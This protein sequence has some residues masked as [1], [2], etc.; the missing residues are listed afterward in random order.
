[1][2]GLLHA[3]DRLRSLV[4]LELST[5]EEEMGLVAS[6]LAGC[7]LRSLS[8]TM[9]EGA[10]AEAFS[11]MCTL[12]QGSLTRLCRLTLDG[13]DKLV[14]YPDD[15]NIEREPEWLAPFIECIPWLQSL[16]W[17]CLKGM[18]VWSAQSIEHFSSLCVSSL[19][20]CSLLQLDG[21]IGDAG[22]VALA[23]ACRQGA[24]RELQTLCLFFPNAL[25][26]RLSKL[27]EMV[28]V[29]EEGVLPK[30]KAAIMD[31]DGEDVRT[32]G[33]DNIEVFNWWDIRKDGEM[34]DWWGYRD[35][36]KRVKWC[37]MQ[38]ANVT[39]AFFSDRL[40]D[41]LGMHDQHLFPCNAFSQEF[42]EQYGG[43]QMSEEF[44]AH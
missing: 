10:T 28:A 30:L 9:Q 33:Y 7:S 29:V 42:F 14:V 4:E 3:L 6:G 40:R 25:T 21:N 1:M 31:C 23:T 36:D 5:T 24:L 11:P 18:T 27:G 37:C 16:E 20:R 15:P 41:F 19:P 2:T 38:E 32:D 17:L 34:M 39:S 22:L 44:F 13:P 8:L 26:Y 12:F 43:F 35:G